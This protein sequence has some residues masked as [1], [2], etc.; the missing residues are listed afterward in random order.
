MY[1]L[2]AVVLF[3]VTAAFAQGNEKRNVCVDE[4]DYNSKIGSNWVANLRNNIVQGLMKTGRLNVIDI[5]NLSDL[6]KVNEERLVQ[7]RQSGVE[8]LIKGHYNSLECVAKTKDGKT[9]YETRSDFSLT[10][11]NTENGA[12]IGTQNFKNTWYSGSTEAESIT[13]ALEEAIGDMR[14]FVDN[15]FKM[16]AIIKAID[17]VD[18]KKGVKT[19]YVTL[20]SDAGIQP[21]QVFD[22]YQEIEVVGEKVTKMIGAAKAKEVVSAGL[23][24]CTITKGGVEIKAAFDNNVKLIVISKAKSNLLDDF[25][26]L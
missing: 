5:A 1:S 17:Q 22:V 7:L 12:V 9:D 26:K 11:V 21:G 23:T 16:E 3:C 14:K 20:G 8:V 18:P 10:L 6:S 15:N 13:K 25:I 19:A 2:L 24:L 4:F